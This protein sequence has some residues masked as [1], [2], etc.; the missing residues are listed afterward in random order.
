MGLYGGGRR[1]NRAVLLR[2]VSGG[3]DSGCQRSTAEFD[4]LREGWESAGRMSEAYRLQPDS[5]SSRSSRTVSANLT[6]RP[7]W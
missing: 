5:L 1:A 6:S 3:S 2:F 7:A 4:R